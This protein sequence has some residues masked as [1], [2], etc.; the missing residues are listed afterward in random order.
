MEHKWQ[1]W[2]QVNIT[3]YDDNVHGAH[4]AGL[5]A[6]NFT[7]ITSMELMWQYWLQVRIKLYDNNIHGTHVAGLV[8]GK[9]HA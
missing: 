6:S 5:A 9:H 4:V 3:L 1:G 7:T 2:V 8:V